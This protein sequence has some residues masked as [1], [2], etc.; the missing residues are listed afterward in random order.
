MLLKQPDV[1]IVKDHIIKI[2]EKIHNQIKEKIKDKKSEKEKLLNRKSELLNEAI[3]NLDR[4][5]D[6]AAIKRIFGVAVAIILQKK[7]KIGNTTS[8][9][10]LLKK[11]INED[12]QLANNYFINTS[13]EREISYRELRKF[14]KLQLDDQDK[15]VIVN[16]NEYGELE[17]LFSYE[18]IAYLDKGAGYEK[19]LNELAAVP[20]EQKVAANSDAKVAQLLYEAKQTSGF[21][22][23]GESLIPEVGLTRPPKLGESSKQQQKETSVQLEQEVISKEGVIEKKTIPDTK[24]QKTEKAYYIS[25]DFDSCFAWNLHPRKPEWW[26]NP[27]EDGPESSPKRTEIRVRRIKWIQENEKKLIENILAGNKDLFEHVAKEMLKDGFTKLCINVGTNRQDPYR[28]YYNMLVHGSPSFVPVLEAAKEPIAKAIAAQLKEGQL[29]T[30]EYDRR[31]M[32]STTTSTRQPGDT[33]L[34]N[35]GPGISDMGVAA[36]KDLMSNSAEYIVANAREGILSLFDNSKITLLYQQMH[37]AFELNPGET[38]FNFYDDTYD[39]ILKPLQMFFKENPDFIPK[40]MTLHLHYYAKTQDNPTA[41]IQAFPPIEG[42]GKHD[43]NYRDTML[44]VGA[45]A[46]EYRY[47]KIK[48]MLAPLRENSFTQKDVKNVL[49]EVKPYIDA[50]AKDTYDI[51]LKYPKGDGGFFTDQTFIEAR[52]RTALLAKKEFKV[53]DASPA[54]SQFL[55]SAKGIVPSEQKEEQPNA[56]IEAQPRNRFA[57]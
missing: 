4:I 19:L 11:L 34:S 52:E 43:P 55:V 50:M 21:N 31:L 33:T 29:I 15:P 3:L 25:L 45:L 22:P 53:G 1:A 23:L 16:K 57:P 36:I 5:N 18:R 14:A 20:T 48:E 8:E 30:V 6:S 24:I 38:V 32:V 37:R 17:K 12:K 7:G 39:G 27:K 9:G 47:P 41:T 44:L 56:E 51:S 2:L 42:T 10:E 35:P 26:G 46:F 40:G 54:R 28:D 49:T 13:D